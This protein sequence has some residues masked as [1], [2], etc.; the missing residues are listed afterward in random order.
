MERGREREKRGV[1]CAKKRRGTDCPLLSIL[2]SPCFAVRA[3]SLFHSRPNKKAMRL[4]TA[5]AFALV[6]AVAGQ[7][8]VEG[9]AEGAGECVCA[10]MIG[11]VERT[12]CTCA[13]SL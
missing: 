11:E 5:L 8:F 9:P 3:P 7:A 1:W 12:L 4:R 2:L 10:M 13:S 6:G